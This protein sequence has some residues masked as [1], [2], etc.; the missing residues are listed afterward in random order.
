MRAM[1]MRVHHL[2]CG[3][4]CPFSA[5]LVNGT[6]GYFER[7]TLVCHCLLVETDDGLVLVDTGLGTA[8]VADPKG[9]LGAGFAALAGAKL[10]RDET[11]LAHVTRLGFRAE[12]VRHI[13]P[14]HMDLDHIGGLSDFPAATVHVFHLEHAAAIE[15]RTLD[16]RAR[17]RPVQWAHRPN[18][19]IHPAPSG[20][21]WF[22]FEAVRAIG[23]ASG[24]EVLLVPLHGHTR[25]HCGVAVRTQNEW[26]LHAGDAYFHHAE[27]AD[28]PSCPAGLDF[29]QS[30]VA[31]DDAL[32][33]ANQA[34]LRELALT[35]AHDVR[36]F[37]AHCATELARFA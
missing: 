17:Y 5:R 25:G 27:I 23:A 36:V 13:V 32:R 22:G 21:R 9:R 14:T 20:E 16:E 11:A 19:R 2:N 31:I 29:F 6:G 3:T 33:R 12:D 8:D 26:L 10:D 37:S 4:M 24:G 7:A 35:H 18:W 15:R 34:R 30:R 1:A 28:V